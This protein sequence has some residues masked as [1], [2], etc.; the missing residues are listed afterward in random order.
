MD[1]FRIKHRILLVGNPNAG[2][3]MLFNRLTGLKARVANYPG[4]TV[5]LREGSMHLPS[6]NQI[7]M[8]DLPGTYSLHARS[9]DEAV[10]VNGVLGQLGD[11]SSNDLIVAVVDATQLKRNLYLVSQLL[12]LKKPLIIALTM[13]DEIQKQDIQIDTLL[14]SQKLSV[15]VIPVSSVTQMGID[16]LLTEIDIWVHN[17]QVTEGCAD[18]SHQIKPSS[19]E[20][21]K[22][23]Q[24]IE[25]WL[26]EVIKEPKRPFK[27]NLFCADDILLHRFWGPIFL[28]IIFATMF[29]SL[30]LGAAPFMDGIDTLIAYLSSSLR[31]FFPIDSLLGSLIIDGIIAGV[32]SVLIFIPL[33]AILFFFIGVL[34]DSG[35]LA[36]ATFLLDRL[37]SKVGLSGRAFVPLLSGF[38]CAVPAIMATRV[39]ESKKDRLVTI[40]ITPLLSCSARLPVYGLLI[41]A[42]FSDA[43]PFLGFIEIGAVVMFAMY[44]IG[45]V[46]A[47]GMAAFFKKFVLKG[48]T[49]SL[50]L[51]LPPYRMPSWSSLAQNIRTRIWLF[52]CEAGT[53]ILA[54]TIILWGLFAFP[55]HEARPQGKVQNEIQLQIKSSYAGQ[56]GQLIEPMVAPLGF[57]WKI[58]LAILSSFAAREVFVSTLGVMYGVGQRQGKTRMSLQEAIQKDTDPLTGKPIYTPLVAL[59]L[60]IFYSLAM[61]CMSTLASTK[62]ETKSWCWPIV[63]FSYMTALAWLCSFA[64]FQAGS[65]LGF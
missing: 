34:E 57:D 24:Q 4:I 12:E 42:V 18:K 47:F 50:I 53:V 14:L 56:L 38:A 64:L 26:Q 6:K 54:M 8:V 15:P 7:C 32:G 29:E 9:E 49:P 2:K 39:I 27:K 33:I 59:S 23:Y 35:Y 3:S 21:T 1:T 30:F 37:M 55:R 48:P 41:V 45:I 31:P 5:E 44:A 19:E 52:L 20:I 36:R 58:S 25:T 28:V 46:A 61:Q 51:E 17:C 10:T 40:L 16:D 65:A 62:K 22:K 43:P 11:T 13:M 60:M 63:Q